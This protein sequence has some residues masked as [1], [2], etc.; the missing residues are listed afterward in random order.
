MSTLKELETMGGFVSDKP[1]KKEITFTLDSEEE[2]TATIHVKRLNI[3]EFEGLFLADPDERARTAKAISVG[4][5]LGENGTEVIPFEKAYKLHPRLAAAMFN[6]FNE[7]NMAKKS[8][9]PAKG[10]SAT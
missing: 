8:S 6:A 7:V 10:S 1:V 2:I 4:I 3:G 5:R 9:R